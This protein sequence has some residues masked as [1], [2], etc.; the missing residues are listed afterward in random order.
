M[1]SICDFASAYVETQQDS[2]PIKMSKA[3]PKVT[4]HIHKRIDGVWGF[5]MFARGKSEKQIVNAIWFHNK[6]KVLRENIRAFRGEI[7]TVDDHRP[8][9]IS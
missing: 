4:F 5:W 9:M 6:G 1:S 3:K 2:T 7:P 8:S